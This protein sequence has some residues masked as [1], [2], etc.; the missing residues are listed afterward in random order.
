M[1]TLSQCHPVITVLLCTFSHSTSAGCIAESERQLISHFKC[2][3]ESFLRI[4]IIPQR[5]AFLP[6]LTFGTVL[7][8]LPQPLQR[9]STRCIQQHIYQ[10]YFKLWI[11]N[12]GSSNLALIVTVRVRASINKMEGLRKKP[13]NNSSACILI[14]GESIL[15]KKMLNAAAKLSLKFELS[16]SWALCV[17]I[18]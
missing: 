12:D 1:S 5:D 17:H 13:Q 6:W 4:F 8:N 3:G 16:M 18:K 2:P 14:A 15:W 10:S 11:S 9:I 7:Y